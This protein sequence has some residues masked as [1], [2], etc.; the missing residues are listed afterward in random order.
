MKTL[1]R[2]LCMITIILFLTA[3]NSTEKPDESELPEEI[4][5]SESESEASESETMDPQYSEM[6]EV[7]QSIEKRW[8]YIPADEWT[9]LETN[10]YHENG[11]N[12]EAAEAAR[13]YPHGS[14]DP[15]RQRHEPVRGYDLSRITF[16]T[17]KAQYSLDDDYVVAELT[18]RA[19]SEYEKVYYHYQINVERWNGCSWDRLILPSHMRAADWAIPYVERGQTGILKWNPHKAV[20][21]VTPGRYRIVGYVDYVPVYAEFEMTE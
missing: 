11:L 15:E 9:G 21:K 16:K 13:H 18:L 8:G 20:T 1:I 3:C 2:F 14:P 5:L 12:I 7:Q 10:A 6:L 19:D 4:V 17:Q